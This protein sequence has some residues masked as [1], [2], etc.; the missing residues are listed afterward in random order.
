M[1]IFLRAAAIL[2]EILI[3]S[4]I[5]FALLWAVRLIVF[6]LGLRPKYKKIVTVALV[7]G[8]ALSLVFFVA[9]LITFY[10]TVTG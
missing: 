9:H 7:T 4:T 8:G 2:V 5:M 6:D 10:P 1:D 3:L